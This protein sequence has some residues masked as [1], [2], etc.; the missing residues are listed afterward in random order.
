MRYDLSDDQILIRDTV[1]TLCRAE[2]APHA[3]RWDREAIVP[4]EAVAKLAEHG[5]LGM[6]IPEEW[7]GVGYDARTVALVIE[8]IA[9][10]SAALAIMVSVHNSVGAVP[11]L[12]YGTE[13]QKRRF[14]PRLVSKELSAFSISEPD[15]G[16]DAGHL[17]ATAVRKDGGYVLNGRKNWVTNGEQA[18][19][20]LIFART[21]KE[22][23]NKGISAFVVESGAPGLI[24]GKAEDKMGLRGSDTVSLTLQDL[25]VPVEQRLGAEGDG[26]RIALSALDAGRIGVG[27]QSLGVAIAAFEEAVAYAQQRQAFGQPLAKIQAI[28]FKLAEMER[29]I[30]CARLL[31]QRAA[32]LKDAGRPFAREA[33][34][35]KLYA[36]EAATWITHQAIQV[37]GGYGYVK[38]YAVERYYR[39]ARVMEIY[40]GTSEIQRLVIARSLLKDGVAV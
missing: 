34:M 3:E 1:R 24:V 29:R 23:G 21:N 16:S 14:L 4:R 18:G 9:R 17:H 5:F 7:G 30:Q 2:F 25:E 26:F 31:I 12:R 27:A 15:A 38:E 11:V 35:A 20:Y 13:E 33:S 40:E 39:D 19:L 37:H 6:A 36:S 22:I 8:E 28:Q 10:V 32:W